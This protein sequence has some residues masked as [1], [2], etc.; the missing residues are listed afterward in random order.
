MTT[1]IELNDKWRVRLNDPAQWILERRQGRPGKKNT[2]Y[3]GRSY[4]TRRHVLL[5]DL[6]DHCGVVCIAAHRQVE[7]LP[8]RFPYEAAR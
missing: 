5:R 4:C 1:T 8:E 3:A 2:G 7:A 6:R